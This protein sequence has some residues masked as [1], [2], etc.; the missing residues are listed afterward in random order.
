VPRDLDLLFDV[1]FLPNPHFVAELRPLTGLDG[2]IVE[3]LESK[4]EVG[5]TLD[6]LMDL[7]EFLLPRYLREGK[8]YV[9]IGIGCT[10]GR[11]RSVY[12]A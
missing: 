1:R 5:E 7:L 12:L 9:R 4:P 10:G 3:Y 6:R 2:A 8:S 11:H